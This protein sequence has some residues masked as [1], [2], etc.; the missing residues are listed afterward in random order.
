MRAT[1]R[2]SFE[3]GAFVANKD[4]A[5]QGE[6]E[7]RIRALEAENA[8]LRKVL[9]ARTG[10]VPPPFAERYLQSILDN[11]PSMIGYW[12]NNLRN[13]FGNHA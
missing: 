4:L 6:L 11:M 10:K 5:S 8:D 2:R 9:A 13:G 1:I 12:D 7:G 3:F